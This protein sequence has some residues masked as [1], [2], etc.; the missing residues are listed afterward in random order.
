MLYNQNRVKT[1]EQN[2]DCLFLKE[3]KLYCALST[4]SNVSDVTSMFTFKILP[5]R[6]LSNV[7]ADIQ[8]VAGPVPLT[9]KAATRKLYS[10][11]RSRPK[12]QRVCEISTQEFQL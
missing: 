4:N 12:R 3:I 10:V 5:S 8:S 1:I 7:S 11:P 2:Q 6:S 9:V